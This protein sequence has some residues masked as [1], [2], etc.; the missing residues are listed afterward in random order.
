MF[1]HLLLD[2]SGTDQVDDIKVIDSQ[3]GVIQI[4]NKIHWPMHISVVQT[5]Q[6]CNKN[7]TGGT[8]VILCLG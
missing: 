1:P 7:Q 8:Q 6:Q 5:M 2:G 4:N 3:A